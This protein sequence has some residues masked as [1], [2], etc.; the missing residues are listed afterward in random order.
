VIILDI[1]VII[2]LRFG[3][4]RLAG[5]PSLRLKSGYAQDDTSEEDFLQ[6]RAV[7]CIKN[8]FLNFFQDGG[9]EAVAGVDAREGA[10]VGAAG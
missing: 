9:E 2:G 3:W 5:D 7:S 8:F 1:V 4:V 6:N 10:E